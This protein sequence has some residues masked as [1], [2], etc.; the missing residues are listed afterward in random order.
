LE[1]FNI[2]TQVNNPKKY[3]LKNNSHL[4]VCVSISGQA[5]VILP[6]D[7]VK[8]IAPEENKSGDLIV[9][10][11]NK[12]SLDY[13]VGR[14]FSTF[15]GI[16]TNVDQHDNVKIIDITTDYFWNVRINYKKTDR[17]KISAILLSGGEIEASN[18][19]CILSNISH[20]LTPQAYMIDFRKN[21]KGVTLD[22][23]SYEVE[24]IS[25]NEVEVKIN[26]NTNIWQHKIH[27][28]QKNDKRVV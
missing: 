28:Y 14:K 16:I 11:G 27:Q 5:N 26:K 18:I 6:G 3:I 25:F 13:I 19:G 22:G 10:P 23:Y 12:K 4:R 1:L 24:H 8:F 20:I 7:T 9:V 2:V 17:S 21:A 15:D